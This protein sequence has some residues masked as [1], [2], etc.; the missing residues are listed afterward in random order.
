MRHRLASLQG[1]PE[2]FGIEVAAN[3]AGIPLTTLRYHFDKGRIMGVRRTDAGR[4][5]ISQAGF[6]AYLKARG[7]DTKPVKALERRRAGRAW[8]RPVVRVRL[9]MADP[10]H[11][12]RI[13][14]RG[15]GRLANQSRSGL[16][17]K[18]LSWEGFMPGPGS[19]VAFTVLGG[20][21]QGVSGKA[22]PS[23]SV[24]RKGVAQ[25][26]LHLLALEA[27]A[28]AV[29]DDFV[30]RGLEAQARLAEQPVGT[31]NQGEATWSSWL[32]RRN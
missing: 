30:A 25:M 31:E 6:F 27:G 12:G 18:A 3:L 20:R 29:W 26:G 15:E 24:C 17:L 9:E 7:I 13:L 16:L 1:L 2:E 5:L 11:A 23:W 32:D 10:E 22:R 8:M 21:L 19:E 14:G 4:R 28:R